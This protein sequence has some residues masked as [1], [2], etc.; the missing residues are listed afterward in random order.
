MKIFKQNLY[1]IF[2]IFIT[3]GSWNAQAGAISDFVSGIANGVF[4][5]GWPTATYTGY[6]IDDVTS[7]Y[8]GYDIVVKFKGKSSFCMVEYCPLW[9]RLKIKVNKS[10]QVRDF[11]LLN[12]NSILQKPFATTGALAQAMRQSNGY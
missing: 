7:H 2:F 11:V 3:L 1:I 6:E 9:F 4:K 8:A 5:V 12:Y 10:F